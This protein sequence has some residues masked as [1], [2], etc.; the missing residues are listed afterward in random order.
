MDEKGKMDKQDKYASIKKMSQSDREEILEYALQCSEKI[1]HG[2]VFD[3]RGDEEDTMIVCKTQ[4]EARD[5]AKTRIEPDL[6]AEK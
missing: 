2:K 4:D 5:I 3:C 1:L 6:E